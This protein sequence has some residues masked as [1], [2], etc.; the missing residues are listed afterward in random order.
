VQRAQGGRDRHRRDILD[1][2]VGAAHAH[3]HLLQRGL[4]QFLGKGRV[5]QPGAGAREPDHQAIADQLVRPHVL[6]RNDILDPR[7][8]TSGLG[9]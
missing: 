1:A 7:S 9:A 4:Q 5:A 6:D 8:S 3:P 2:Q